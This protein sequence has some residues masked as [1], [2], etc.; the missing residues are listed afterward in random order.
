MIY[1]NGQ[2]Y[3]RSGNPLHLVISLTNEDDEPLENLATAVSIKFQIKKN[4][5]D[6]TPVVSLTVGHGITVDTPLEGDVTIAASSA[7]MSL[8]EGYYYPELQVEQTAG[9]DFE[10]EPYLS[11][12]DNGV[13]IDFDKFQIMTGIII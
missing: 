13:L 8:P 1:K 5:W 11:Y 2:F 9:E 7:V 10:M 6:I 4:I 3:H 12:R